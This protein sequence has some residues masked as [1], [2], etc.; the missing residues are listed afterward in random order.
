MD[1]FRISTNYLDKRLTSLKRS[2]LKRLVLKSPAYFLRPND[3][4]GLST[5]AEGSWEPETIQII[6]H[7]AKA[8]YSDVFV[9]IG[10]NIGLIACQAGALFKEVHLFEPNP[11]C[12]HVL[13]ANLAIALPEKPTAIYPFG[14]GDSS[15]R[16]TMLIP[17]KNLGGAFIPNDANDYTEDQFNAMHGF[18][19]FSEH[20]YSKQTVDIERADDVFTDLFSN[21]YKKNL[22]NVL[23][24][25]DVEG[26]ER[27][28]LQSIVK[29]KPDGCHFAVIFENWDHSS[30][31]A[32]DFYA[33]LSQ[34]YELYY[35]HQPNG[36]W[37]RLLSMI[38]LSASPICQSTLVP[39]AGPRHGTF[40]LV[41]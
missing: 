27:V 10:A 6:N 39:Y 20:N 14:L 26:M 40:V 17:H 29:Q 11:I 9:D 22:C 16:V 18:H 36:L 8:G 31:S 19:A 4:I 30:V 38:G 3:T 25:I 24:K 5:M 41:T 13:K 21:L 34:Q 35:L 1:A 32:I 7:L 37:S 28:I 2:I 12:V 15:E 33:Q 23:I